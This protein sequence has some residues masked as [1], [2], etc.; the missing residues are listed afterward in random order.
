[1]ALGSIKDIYSEDTY[2]AQEKLNQVENSKPGEYQSQYTD[3]INGLLDNILNRKEF[4]YDFNADPLYQQYKDQYTTL[5]QQAMMDTVA[6]A[7]TMTGGYGN[8]YGVT[9]GVQ[10]NQ[11]YL[12]QLNN[13][14]PDLYNAA[15][16]KYDNETANLYNQFSALGSQEDREYGKYRDTVGDWQNDRGYYYDKYA[17]SISNDQYVSDYNQDEDQFNQ[18]MALAWAQF[19]YQKE[20]DALAMAANQMVSTGSS[21]S[22]G[23]SRSSSSKSSSTSSGNSHGVTSRVSANQGINYNSSGG[24]AAQTNVVE[25]M[26]QFIKTNSA[27]DEAYKDYLTDELNKGTISMGQATQ[28]MSAL[29]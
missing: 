3:K 19:N 10:A 5:G 26:A 16:K 23:S 9:A 24:T 11:A 27:N 6:N 4:S 12:Q 18:E 17:G 21:G 29:K 8:S 15:L 28:I 13:I 20:K 14:I 25:K 22:S 7:A 2:Q 1:M